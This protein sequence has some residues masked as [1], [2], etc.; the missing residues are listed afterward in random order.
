MYPESAYAVAHVT[1]I[2]HELSQPMSHRLAAQ[3]ARRDARRA[4]WNRVVR[5]IDWHVV[6]RRRHVGRA[7]AV[8]EV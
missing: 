1:E 6:G 4:R 5:G 2:N 8:A 7:A 3:R